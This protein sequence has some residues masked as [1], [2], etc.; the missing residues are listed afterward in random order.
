MVFGGGVANAV[1]PNTMFLA[2]LGLFVLPIVEET[3]FSRTTVTG[4]YSVAAVGMAIG[5]VIVGQLVDRFA[6]RYIL[7]PAFLLFSVSLALIGLMPPIAQFH[8]IPCFFVGFFGAG[9]AVPV[10]RAVVTW[11]DTTGPSQSGW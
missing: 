3:G 9:T 11:F 4:A 8:V 5:L 7:V 1:G 2:T 6:A 10:A